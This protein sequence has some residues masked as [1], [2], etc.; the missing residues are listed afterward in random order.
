MQ[1]ISPPSRSTSAICKMVLCPVSEIYAA[2]D[3]GLDEHGSDTDS[4]PT[5]VQA[6]ARYTSTLVNAVMQSSRGKMGPLSSLSTKAVVSTITFRRSRQSVQMESRRWTCCRL[7]LYSKTGP[8]C[9]FTYTGYRTAYFAIYQEELCLPY[10]HG[11]YGD[12]EM[13][14]NRYNVASPD[15]AGC[16]AAGYDGILR[17]QQSA[18]DDTANASGAKYEE[19]LLLDQGTLRAS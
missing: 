16:G 4:H 5:N 8:T 18:V 17:F 14:E 13:I 9:D 7:H 19:S 10:S 15:Q 3:A 6:G 1:R 2:S 12:S 11:Y